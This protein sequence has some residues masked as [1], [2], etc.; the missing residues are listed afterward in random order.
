METMKDSEIKWMGL[1]PTSWTTTK[2]KYTAMG[3][4]TLFLDGDWI[5]SDIIEDEG[6]RYLTSGNVGAGIY[7]D[8]G[9]SYI[10]E[11]TFNALH[12]LKV[13]PGDIM[14]SRLNEPVGRACFVPEG[15]DY[16]VVAVDDVILR[17]SKEYSK[18][19]LVY[20]MNCSGYTEHA[21]LIARG[22]TMS[23]I[24]RTQLGQFFVPVPGY[25]EQERIAD[26]L[27]EHCAKLDKI[28]ANLERQIELLQ[29][30]K[31]SL[32]TETVTKGLGK[33]VEMKDSGTPWPG[34][35]PEH[36]QVKRLKYICSYITDGSHFSPD[37]VD[38]GFPYITAADVH[39]EGLDYDNA[40]KISEFDFKQLQRAGCCPMKNDVLLVKDGATTGRIGFVTDSTACVVLSSVAILRG[41]KKLDNK[42]LMYLMESDFM[43]SQIEV[44]MAGSAMPRTILAKIMNYYGILCPV[45][46][47][48]EIVT[49]L[50]K[51]CSKIDSILKGKEAQLESLKSFKYSEIYEYVTGKKR[52]KEAV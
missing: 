50:D 49:F 52:V 18:R 42:Y 44:S 4:D 2:L 26:Y 9:N 10:S 24:S 25:Q 6:V 45:E 29:K 51:Q 30:Y 39:G 21:N 31:K 12:C 16:Y 13:F 33:N 23:R 37:T 11:K 17:P 19:Y 22:A 20:V 32:I 1:I 5:E 48:K 14:I 46:E 8:Q 3:N 28:I 43:Q 40:K 34:K 41:N 38:D 35:I 7:K 47:Q 15:E 27:D 36:W